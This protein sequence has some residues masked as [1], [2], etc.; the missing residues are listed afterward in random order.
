MYVGEGRG[1]DGKMKKRERDRCYSCR[2]ENVLDQLQLCICSRR[3]LSLKKNS[4]GSGWV[5][6]GAGGDKVN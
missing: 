1:D 3:C 6:V 5:G 4:N 2:S